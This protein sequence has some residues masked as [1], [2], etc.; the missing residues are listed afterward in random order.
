VARGEPKLAIR[1]AARALAMHR[2][3]QDA[4]L[5]TEDMRIMAAALGGAGKTQGAK[6]MLRE[7]IERA[8]EHGRPLLVAIAQRDLAQM[9]AREGDVA[10]AK[11]VAQTARATFDRLGAKVEI[12]KLDALLANPGFGTN[13]PTPPPDSL[14]PSRGEAR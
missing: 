14:G 3:L 12:E 11:Q 1:E 8:T 9:R 4:V 10:A 6:D 2:E 13:P 7:V 5:V